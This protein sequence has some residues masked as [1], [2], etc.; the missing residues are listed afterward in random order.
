MTVE[1]GRIIIESPVLRDGFVQV[2]IALLHAH[3]L[4]AGAKLAYSTLLWYAWKDGLYPGDR[5]LA[6]DLGVSERSVRNYMGELKN[7]E[8]VVIAERGLGQTTTYELPEKNFRSDRKNPAGQSGK[9]L[10]VIYKDSDSVQTQDGYGDP[11]SVL[12]QTAQKTANAIGQSDEA[13]QLF[14]TAT[15]RNWT[16]ETLQRA[17]ATTRLRM[18]RADLEPLVSPIR[19]LQDVAKRIH[20]ALL[21]AEAA[22][23]HALEDRRALAYSQAKSLREGLM[24]WPWYQVE[25]ILRDG[26]GAALAAEVVGELSGEEE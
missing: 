16:P 18:E 6:E 1:Q 2:P 12:K 26:F 13:G 15:K 17:A 10:P 24:K 14:S 3:N 19:Y 25:A 5:Q 8:W 11:V 9:S 23:A 20:D 21:A 22:Q 7:A 4:S